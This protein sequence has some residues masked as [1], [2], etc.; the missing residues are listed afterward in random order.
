MKVKPGTLPFGKLSQPAQRALA[1]AGIVLVD[2]LTKIT[3]AEL[4]K[5][6]GIGKNGLQ[7]LKTIMAEKDITFKA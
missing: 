2:D 4:I 3:E 1:N 6:H 7:T 5:L